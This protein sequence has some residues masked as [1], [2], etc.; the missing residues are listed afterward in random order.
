MWHEEGPGQRGLSVGSETPQPL[1]LPGGRTGKGQWLRTQ[2][3]GVS[4][5]AEFW[6]ASR[7]RRSPIEARHASSES[8]KE[9][10]IMAAESEKFRE[11]RTQRS[12]SL[13]TSVFSVSWR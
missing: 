12:P 4:E 3:V 11:G 2:E 7:G 1:Y 13:R 9:G 8:G 6:G 10:E 5:E